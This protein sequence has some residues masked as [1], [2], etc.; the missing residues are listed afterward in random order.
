MS[1]YFDFFC[2]NIENEDSQNS[3]RITGTCNSMCPEDEVKLREQERLIHVLE[4]WG[5][6]KKLVKGYSRS[7][8]DSNMA[9]PHLL[10]PYPVLT[11][12]VQYLLMDITRRVD[13]PASV[14]YDYV[15]DRL[16]AVRQDATIQRL[17][18]E[19]CA[20]LLEPMIRFYVYYGYKLSNLP[21]KDYDPVLNKKY[22]LECMKWYLSCSDSLA[23]MRGNIDHLTG[24]LSSI[25][26][27]G[28]DKKNKIVN[29]RVLIEN[30]YILCN[31]D[32]L[33]PLFRYVKLSKDI[34]RHP[35]LQLA[36]EIAIANLHGNYVRVCRLADKLCPLSYCALFTYLPTLQR[37]ALAVMSHA[38][39]NKRLT[40]PADALAHWLRYREPHDARAACE[41]YG[42]KVQGADVRFEKTD[43]KSDVT[44]NIPN[45]Q[46]IREKFDLSIID[47]F[48]YT[49]PK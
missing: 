22:L 2:K 26:L 47:I 16:R 9:V 48:T 35:K 33:H 17:P 36:Y 30:L 37:R 34:K 1:S 44:L 39:S 28:K 32:D 38:Y 18:P 6:E 45:P 13:V 27:N 42:L 49:T 14:V 40:V 41:H 46:D 43:F 24:F 31:L 11:Y 25:D 10:R 29:D 8:A 5:S 4:V 12:T 20:C 15:N 19:Q 23:T 3:D 7:A 21:L